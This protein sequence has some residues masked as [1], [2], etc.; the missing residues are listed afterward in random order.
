MQF[1]DWKWKGFRIRK[2]YR[3]LLANIF[4]F[5]FFVPMLGYWM[6]M[7]FKEWS[8]IGDFEF[9]IKPLIT[10][11]VI[12]LVIGLVSLLVMLAL[13]Y[14]FWAYLY[15]MQKLCRM[16]YSNEFYLVN[17]IEDPNMMVSNQKSMSRDIVYF[18]KMYFW[19]RKGMFEITIM[20]DGSKFNQFYREMS[21]TFEQMFA[22]A[23]SDT[24]ERNGFYK[25]EMITDPVV[26]RIG[27]KDVV[28]KNKYVLSLMKHITWDISKVA[29]GL[30]IGG[31]GGGK[32]RFLTALLKGLIESGAKL[33]IAD[34]K[35]SALSDLGRV[36]ENVSTKNDDILEM[37]KTVV[38]EMNNRYVIMKA[39]PDYVP[40]NDFS[41]YDMQPIIVLF[42]EVMAVIE[43]IPKKADRDKYFAEMY[44]IVMKGREAGVQLILTTQR[45][46]VSAIPG[47]IRDNLGL[48]IA[49][50]QLSSTAY[51][52]IFD[53]TEQNLRS[54]KGIG[55]GY[56]FQNGYPI[57]KEFYSPF[58][59]DSYN[60]LTEFAQL[61]DVVPR[62]FSPREKESDS[63]TSEYSLPEQKIREII[64]ETEEDTE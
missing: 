55:R 32:T 46:D 7:L 18:P 19:K 51:R 54:K 27:I 44:Q 40:G 58:V 10:I 2:N 9:E 35:N 43:S 62:A 13:F 41:T 6:W 38:A 20:L 14:K 4:S 33:Y 61:L 37:L 26:N 63:A 64:Y 3:H 30:I 5:I 24:T 60:I 49:L 39:R 25:Y 56:I 50:G 53:N 48:K 8:F 34:G 59:P 45:P 12:G 29:H 31:T 11:F 47:A 36:L 17:K 15:H 57:V 52:M 28:V 23:L 42:D 16:I 21:D 22:L 1:I